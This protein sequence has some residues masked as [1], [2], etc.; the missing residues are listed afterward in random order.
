M[1]KF[2]EVL[3]VD[4]TYNVNAIRMPVYGRRWIWQRKSVSIVKMIHRPLMVIVE[5]C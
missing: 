1:E 5:W 3:L 4:G 2:P